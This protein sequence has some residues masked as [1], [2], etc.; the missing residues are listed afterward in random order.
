MGQLAIFGGTFDP[1]HWGHLVV[2]QTALSQLNLELVIWVPA[3]HP[4]HKTG[5]ASVQRRLMVEFA[6]ANHPAFILSPVES[7]P[8]ET[9]Y[10]IKSFTALQDLYPQN[11]WSWII[12]IDAFLTLPRWHGREI[13][14]PACN[15][16]VA[17]RP[18]FSDT[19]ETLQISCQKVVAQL[20]AQEIKIHWQLLQMPAIGISSSL[21]RQY[22]QSG[23]SIRYLVPEVIEDY[24][25]S[26]NLYAHQDIGV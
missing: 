5:L 20:A 24:I 22:C 21:I 18:Y 6:I 7:S 12:G 3:G 25:T 11:H 9:D 16:L 23:R 26:Q 1:I 2:A 13:L 15:W 4:P 8:T 14:I 10:A 17:P 19:T